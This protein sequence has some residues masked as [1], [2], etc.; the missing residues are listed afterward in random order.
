GRDEWERISWDEALTL[1]ANELVKAKERYGNESILHPNIVNVEGYL[2]QLLSA[3]G[4]YVDTAGTQSSGTL[5]MMPQAFGFDPSGGNDR[6]DLENS[7]YIV[8]YGLNAAWSAFGRPS[9]YLKHAKEK[10]CKFVFVGPEYSATAGF[11]NAEWIPVRPGED[12]ALL[13]GVAYSMVTRDEGG[14][15]VDWDFLARCTVGFD[16]DHMPAGAEGAE[17]FMDY[18]M[19]KSDGVAKTQAWASELCGTPVELID[20]F[21]DILSC[22]N[23]VSVHS[24]AAAAR[25]KGA[26]NFPQMLMT[27]GAMG[28]HFGKPGH[29]VAAD[30]NYWA[31]NSAPND[32]CVPDIFAYSTVGMSNAG[33]PCDK[34]VSTDA[35]W[36]AIIEGEYWD[37]GNAW[38]VPTPRP[39]ERRTLD[40]H[41]IANHHQNFLCSQANMKRGIE[42]FRKVD[43]VF[44]NAYY[45]KAD[46]QY[47]DIVFPLTTRWEHN[48]AMAYNY[49]KDKEYMFWQQAFL[50]PRGEAKGDFEYVCLLGE[51]LGIDFAALYPDSEHQRWFNQM[52]RAVIVDPQ[53][54]DPSAPVIPLLSTTQDDLDALDVEGVP[55]PGAVNPLELLENGVFHLHREQ[56]DKWQRVGYAAFVADPEG[57]PRETASGKFEIYCQAKSDLYDAINGRTGNAKSPFVKVSPLPKYLEHP[58]G[59]KE[60]FADWE[61]KTPGAYPVQITHVHYLRRAH[62]DCDNLPWLREALQNPV[63]INK[64]DA[65]ARGIKTGD[66]VRVF[67]EQ[68]AFLRPA[69]VTRTVMPGVLVLPHGAGARFDEET[70][71]DLSGADNVLTASNNTTTPYLNGWNSNLVQYEKYDGPVQLKPDCEVDAVVASVL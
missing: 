53:P 66:T 18:L 20:R 32:A 40:I 38:P 54:A 5:V 30:N 43:F 29:A 59:Y 25:C 55:H 11:T 50:E 16:A 41:V 49:N 63:F 70:G 15:L 27:I 22:K 42:A 24:S 56:G 69:S 13:L 45:M 1:T 61:T 33:N 19:G 31:L 51:K 44:S 64:D 71:I 14:S 28:G 58:L 2:G 36:D 39:L 3:F 60:T 10:G 46:A 4:G 21:A 52:D 23:A 17:S 68:G 67:N 37:A 65:A 34:T 9:M 8:L 35:L 7:E 12:T 47:S 6:F 57:A 48:Q 26:E 62:T